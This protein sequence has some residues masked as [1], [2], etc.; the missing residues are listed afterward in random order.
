M[1]GEYLDAMSEEMGGAMEALHKEL[2]TVRTGRASPK[3]L[4]TVQV[5]VASYGATM[6]IN[7]L[8]TVS[9]PRGWKPTPRVWVTVP[10]LARPAPSA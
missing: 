8:A 9:T 5:T 2:H 4:D 10:W 1:V 7:Q 6:P 3:L